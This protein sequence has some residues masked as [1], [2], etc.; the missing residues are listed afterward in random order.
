MPKW[1][2]TVTH[3]RKFDLKNIDRR[4]VKG[5]RTV[6]GVVIA[7]AVHTVGDQSCKN[8]TEPATGRGR[9]EIIFFFF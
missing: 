9:G 3:S 2:H 8:N 5:T 4:V 7:R 1:F 6:D